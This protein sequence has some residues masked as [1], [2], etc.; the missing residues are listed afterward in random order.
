[1]IPRISS[2][3]FHHCALLQSTDKAQAGHPHLLIGILPPP[4]CGVH[5]AEGSSDV[6]LDKHLTI[7]LDQNTT[8]PPTPPHRLG[9]AE[10]RR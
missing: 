4:D 10:A 2:V 7:S 3:P 8:V 9:G 5:T 6:E 1:M